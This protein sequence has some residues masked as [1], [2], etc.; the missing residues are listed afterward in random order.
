MRLIPSVSRAFRRVGDVYV[1]LAKNVLDPVTFHR[2]AGIQTA[3][4]AFA[5]LLSFFLDK[6]FLYMRKESAIR[7]RGRRVEG[8]LHS[9]DSVLLVDDLVAVVKACF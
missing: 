5:S 6:P 8:L 2:V 3:G 7:G 9:G 4:I 1:E